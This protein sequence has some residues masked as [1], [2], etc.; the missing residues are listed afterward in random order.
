MKMEH[1]LSVLIWKM[2]KG[3]ARA[4]LVNTGLEQ[5]GKEKF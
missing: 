2:L 5:K 3:A 1:P 4:F